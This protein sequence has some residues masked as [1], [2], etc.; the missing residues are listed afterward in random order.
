[1]TKKLRIW[2]TISLLLIASML[3]LSACGSQPA[4]EEQVD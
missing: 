1:M 2:T 4:A 3:V